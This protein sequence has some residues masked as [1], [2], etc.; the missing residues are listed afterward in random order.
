[1]FKKLILPIILI[2]LSS[3]TVLAAPPIVEKDQYSRDE[4]KALAL[5]KKPIS[6]LKASRL[7]AGSIIKL[8]ANIDYVLDDNIYVLKDHFKIVYAYID[9]SLAPYGSLYSG[10]KLQ[11]VGQQIEKDGRLVINVAQI[12]NIK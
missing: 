2:S 5:H 8:N 11:V 3:S 4:I 12:S 1:M 9:P 10:I 6:V 7:P